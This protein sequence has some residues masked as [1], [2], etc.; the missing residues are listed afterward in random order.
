MKFAYRIA[1]VVAALGSCAPGEAQT[2]SDTARCELHFWG[3]DRALTS[4]Y[5]GVTGLIGEALAGP[6]PQKPDALASDLSRTAQGEVLKTI[7][8]SAL[9]KMPNLDLVIEQGPA[10]RTR[11]KSGEGR[12]TVSTAQCYAELIVDYI[13]YTSHITAGRKFGARFWLR[14]LGSVAG[15]AQV[16]NG[17]KDVKMTV[18]PAKK[19]EDQPAA[20]VELQAAFGKAVEGFLLNKVK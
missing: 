6:S 14:R 2:S 11:V 4:S 13:G 18:Y 8:L 20:L 7:D 12:L 10:D 1:C 3:S 9:L 5:S 16:Q 19:L 17:G 15:P